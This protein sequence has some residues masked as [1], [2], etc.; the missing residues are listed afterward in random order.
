MEFERIRDAPKASEECPKWY[1]KAMHIR[2]QNCRPWGLDLLSSL[3]PF[4]GQERGEFSLVGPCEAK[5]SDPWVFL[6]RCIPPA[7]HRCASMHAG[8][9]IRNLN[10]RVVQAP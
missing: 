9:V 6:D 2:I 7:G 8:N 10:V 3:D 4:S 1:P 5:V